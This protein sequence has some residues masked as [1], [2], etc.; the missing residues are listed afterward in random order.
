[1]K[2]SLLV[3]C[4]LNVRTK[5][6]AEGSANTD[7]IVKKGLLWMQ[8]DKLF[9]QWKERFIIL[10]AEYLQ[11]F[12]KANSQITD[13]GSFLLKIRLSEIGSVSLEDR[14]GYLTLSIVARREGR[15]LL[16][17]TSGIG[18]WHTSVNLLVK[19][20]MRHAK[21]AMQSTK[22]FW[23]RRQKSDSH[24]IKQW[25]LARDRIGDILFIIL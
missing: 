13:M 3:D 15:L 1:M 14:R 11:I 12:K 4:D 6:R 16:R 9:S 8:Q 5:P 22:E 21:G 23:D 18:E 17:N 7:N 19:E 25:L 10:T 20:K 24:D 2:K